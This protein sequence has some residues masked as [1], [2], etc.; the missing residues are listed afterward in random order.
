[1]KKNRRGPS[2]EFHS[3]EKA[4]E[5]SPDAHPA[6]LSHCGQDAV[7][8][9]EPSSDELAHS[10]IGIDLVEKEGIDQASTAVDTDSDTDEDADALPDPVVKE[11]L[12]PVSPKAADSQAANP[13]PSPD[14]V[15]DV[16]ASESGELELWPV[17]STAAG[18]QAPQRR[19]VSELHQDEEV[20][21][22]VFR[23]FEAKRDE[24]Q[25][26][27]REL[28]NVNSGSLLWVLVHMIPKMHSMAGA[29]YGNW[30]AI[31]TLRVQAKHFSS[32]YFM[33]NEGTAC[34]SAKTFGTSAAEKTLVSGKSLSTGY[35]WFVSPADLAG[36]E[37]CQ[38]VAGEQHL[39]AKGWQHVRREGPFN[40]EDFIKEWSKQGSP[41][42][43]ASLQMIIE[44]MS[45]L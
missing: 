24:A 43:E 26:W 22:R 2:K 44:G 1:M 4:A 15:Y 25:P 14:V 5:A 30:F 37:S 20:T 27:E 36:D 10:D 41:M 9:S 19:R 13:A 21:I 17:G 16:V 28:R 31:H 33:C 45:V 39:E 34:G 42:E 38:D 32:R 29:K 6:G 40:G 7:A 8:K 11:Q 18:S 35:V 23:F 12:A 3:V